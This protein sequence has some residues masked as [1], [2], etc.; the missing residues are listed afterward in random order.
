[1][2]HAQQ[3]RVDPVAPHRIDVG[4]APVAAEHAQQDR[5]HDVVG[6]AASVARVG[7]RAAPHELLPACPGLEELEEEN[8]L[9]FP[10]DRGLRFPLGI[11]SSARRVHRPAAAA[12]KCPWNALTLRVS[13]HQAAGLLHDC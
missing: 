12:G 6:T 7:K 9:P 11:K 4:V 13:P 2:L 5:A 1:M 10:G 8:Q 3:R